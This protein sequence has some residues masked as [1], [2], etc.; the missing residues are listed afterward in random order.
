MSKLVNKYIITIIIFYIF[1]LGLLPSVLSKTVLVLCENFSHNTNYKISVQNPK[2]ILSPIPVV[3]LKADAVFFENKKS[4]DSMGSDKLQAQIRLLPLLVGK[5]HVNS[6][7]IENFYLKKELKKDTRLDENF[8][9]NLKKTRFT[10]DFVNVDNFKMIF[11]SGESTKNI[12]YEGKRFNFAN[13]N[14]YAGFNVDSQ[15]V[16]GKSSS[17]IFFNLVLPKNNNIR[18]TKFDIE[19]SQLD[20]APIGE[21]FKNFIPP[22]IEGL[23]GKVNIYANKD[24]LKTDFD[25]VKIIYKD[26]DYSIVF[27]QR[28][29]LKAGFNIYQN[30][31]NL[32]YAEINSQKIHI[33]AKGKIQD[34]FG[35]AMPTADL[36][37]IINKSEI[38]DLI[39]I[40]PPFKVEEFDCYKLKKYKFYGD[41]L[42]NIN[43]TGKFPEPNL[44]GRLFIDNGIL[45]K[46]IPNTVKG[47]TIK[48]AF[49]G[50]QV[51]YDISVPAGGNQKVWVKGSQELYATKYAELTVKSTSAVNLHSAE[52]VVN[53]LH[54]I[55]NFIVGPLPILDVYGTG[56]ID[57]TVKGT[58]TFPH[59]WGKLNFYNASVNFL[60]IPDLKLKEAEAVLSFNDTNAVFKTTKGMVNGKDFSINGTCNLNGDFDFDVV[61]DGQPSGDLYNAI[62]TSTMIDYIKNLTPKLDRI[63]GITNLKLKIYGSLK[64]IEDLK[65]NVNAF[66]KGIITLNDNEI[67]FLGIDINRANAE[68]RLDGTTAKAD[69]KAFLDNSPFH[70]TAGIKNNL[71]AVNADFPK[72]NLNSVMEDEY[73]R[74]QKYLPD[75]I[76]SAG[77]KG[78]INKI[79]Y[80]K[81]NFNA[82]IIPDKTQSMFKYN[83]GQIILN[84]G[85][86]TIKNLDFYINDLQN[87]MKADLQI[88]D[89][90]SKKPLPDGILKLKI[91]DLKI[92]N[93]IFGKKILPKQ[94]NEVLKDYEFSKGSV[95]LTAK[96]NNGK[97]STESNLSGIGFN[98]LPMD[99]PVEILNG[100]INVRN[101]DFKLNAIN[102]LVDKMPLLF[103]GEVK[104]I[105]EK[106]NFN[107]Y[108]NSKPRQDFIDKFVN[109]NTIYPLKIKGD[110]V[111]NANIKGTSND[112]D[113]DAK[114]NIA[115]DSSI[116]Y[117]GATVGDIEN[118]IV[119]NLDSKIRNNKDIRIKEFLY[120]K[121][122]DSQSGKQTPLNLLKVR[123]GINVLKDD[124]EFKDL[125]IKTSHPTDVRIFN[126]LFGKPNIKQGQFTSDLKIRGKLSNPKII[127]DFYIMETNIPFLDTTI[128]N[129]EF[130]FK[131]RTLEIKSKG[132][133]LG[134]DVSIDAVL[135]NKLTL[136]YYIE[137]AIITTNDMNL[138]RVVDK[139]KSAE[140]ENEQAQDNNGIF[141]I[142]SVVV[143][144]LKLKADKIVLRNIHAT[145]FVADAGLNEQ[146]IFEIKDFVFNIAQG[147]LKG[148]YSY[149][150]KNNNM[151]LSM[152]ANNI[153]ANDITW[154]LFDIQNQIYGNLT[155]KT[156]LSCNGDNFERCMQTLNGETTF[157]VKDGKMPKLGSLEYLLKA[158]NIVKGGITGIS[159]NGVIDLISPMKTGEFS[160]IYGSVAIKDGVAH[161]VEITTQGKDL[162]LFIS[163]KYDFSTSIA[164]M[165]VLGL[166]SQKIS[167]VL[168]PI[169]NISVNTLF[170]MIPGVD[171]SKDSKVL[172][173][174]NK[175]PGVEISNKAYRKF[176]AEIMG[177]INGDNY[178][179]SFKW[180]N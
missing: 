170:N 126:I 169:G 80:D 34:Y 130:L 180:I 100:K 9:K 118:S 31:I 78:D 3:K 98:Y 162:S 171:L 152:N 87:Y 41:V 83:S 38:S 136:P 71:A 48:L 131:D 33:K 105:T 134:N 158:G 93:E 23:C 18:N 8:F 54:E 47:A 76:L 77:Y 88:F 4:G 74:R 67:T 150:L 7:N 52:E 64:K 146:R 174:I 92:L 46:P 57:L 91:V 120:N 96:F 12:V 28:I 140:A 173:N 37:V 178:V 172:E 59:A 42:G 112:Y 86:L 50:R 84:N 121:I 164:D 94:I 139:L 17:K 39:G 104:N 97:L 85:K 11:T 53:P 143:N 35:K 110:I 24:E 148:K 142:N 27:P 5:V 113:L 133:V 73:L 179:T 20:I 138:N 159:I 61:S 119:L 1:W 132:E 128:K 157:N 115:K 6:I 129:I 70:I 149:N 82:K 123:G 156:Y 26:K 176:V 36:K 69:I 22:E 68:I 60:E 125:F 102:V 165:E 72:L 109:R 25:N 161:D 30:L 167:T 10:T 65:F 117:Y 58:R 51:S 15:L 32:E 56:N 63:T 45:I 116:Y 135:R 111:Y 55:L 43:I 14:R 151:K 166:L 44:N 95:N 141:D 66:T 21:F 62:Q 89:T 155:G 107:I 144:N 13:K 75:I 90:F 79:D 127:G 103:D 81:I 163:G 160:N 153:S 154:A 145:N 40:I 19:V 29:A 108:I 2:I 122:I 114:I 49:N 175:I 99:L 106:P 124:L 177:N 101:N 16:S 147:Q 137:R 168:G